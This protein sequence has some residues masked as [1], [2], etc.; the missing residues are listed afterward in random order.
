MPEM[1]WS[2]K[3][4]AREEKKWA[5]ARER[6][7]QETFFKEQEARKQRDARAAKQGGVDA[8]NWKRDNSDLLRKTIQR[9]QNDGR[10]MKFAYI[11]T[12]S[13]AGGTLLMGL[14]LSGSDLQAAKSMSGGNR[15]LKG[16]CRFEGQ[17]FVFETANPAPP[18]FPLVLKRLIR[19][20]TRLDIFLI[21]VRQI[22]YVEEVGS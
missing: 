1:S 14:S 12:G 15:I 22:P 21:E 8:Q 2:E 7:D 13:R 9:A 17:V 11:G 4:A 6:W 16:K 3:Q 10:P 19:E 18:D 20:Q 5:D